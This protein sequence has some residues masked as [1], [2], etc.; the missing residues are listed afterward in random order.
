MKLL[1][2]RFVRVTISPGQPIFLWM[3][4]T[5]RDKVQKTGHEI[6]KWGRKV[7]SLHFE[8]VWGGCEMVKAGGN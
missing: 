6:Y 4:M 8:W 2:T 7:V 3:E 1:K 5:S